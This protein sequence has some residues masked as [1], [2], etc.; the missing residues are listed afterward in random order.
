MG[1]EIDKR[2]KDGN[3]E[4]RIWSTSSDSWITSWM[5]RNSMISLF[6]EQYQRDAKLETIEKFM[7]F[8]FNSAR[9]DSGGYWGD[10]HE[11]ASSYHK[12]ALE[13]VSSG[14]YN[15]AINTKYAEIMEIVNGS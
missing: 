5:S 10:N 2:Q 1:W 12:W 7:K 4:F 14:D 11:G 9:Y 3:E 6:D 15:E 13:A 8:P